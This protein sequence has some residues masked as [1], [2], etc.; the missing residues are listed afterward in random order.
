MELSAVI[1]ALLLLLEEEE[2]FESIP[3]VTVVTDSQYVQCGVQ[4]WMPQWKENSWNTS[5]NK[6]VKNQDLWKQLDSLLK[7]FS[8]K[9]EFEYVK[10]HNTD[11]YNNFVDELAREQASKY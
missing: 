11:I 6:D 1:N 2:Y 9:I 8:E 10:A 7:K 3:L 4:E 5:Q